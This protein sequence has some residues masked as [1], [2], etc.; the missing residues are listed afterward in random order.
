M[1]GKVFGGWTVLSQSPGKQRV[2]AMC[3][4]GEIREDLYGPNLQSGSSASCGCQ[5]RE[6]AREKNTTH[7]MSN[8][9]VFWVWCGIKDRCRNPSN[10]SFKNY[11]GRGIDISPQWE[12]FEAFFRD[13]GPRPSGGYSVE[14]KDNDLGYSKENCYWAT[15]GEQSR[16]TRRT[17]KVDV[18]GT[19]CCLKDVCRDAGI[20][21]TTFRSRCASMGITYQEGVDAG[22]LW[23]GDMRRRA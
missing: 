17:L 8:D 3:K 7:G 22:L 9:P 14:R 13:M 15:P 10:K 2:T 20:R 12:T 4:C 19:L 5:G 16:N 21:Y 11:G 1:V 6:T 23:Q 18:G